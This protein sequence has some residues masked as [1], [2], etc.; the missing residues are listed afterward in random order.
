MSEIEPT[1]NEAPTEN[2]PL[3]DE[4]VLVARKKEEEDDGD[5]SESEAILEDMKQLDVEKKENE[6][7]ENCS[8]KVQIKSSPTVIEDFIR[9]FLISNE[10]HESLD[11]FQREW[12][13]KLQR[14]D[15]ITAI[16]KIPDIYHQKEKL[17]SKVKYLQQN[18]DRMESITA[19]VKKTW[20][21]LR[22]E[23]DF[24]RMHHRRVLQEKNEL[25]KQLKRLK[26]YCDSYEPTIHSLRVKYENAK[27]EKMLFR[28]DRDKMS[29]KLDAMEEQIKNI[30]SN[31]T[32]NNK[33]STSSKRSC[34]QQ[35]NMKSSSFPTFSL[36]NPYLDSS[37]DE[38]VECVNVEKFSLSKTF[39]V[40]KHAVSKIA[41]HPTKD[42]VATAS[43]DMSWKLWTIPS[44]ELI[45]SGEGHKDWISSLS[46]DPSG[47]HLASASGDCSIKIW[48]FAKSCC[49]AT[50]EDHTSVVWNVKYHFESSNFIVS[51]S[52]D[53]TAKLWDIEKSKCKQTYRG[54]VDSVNCVEFQPYSNNIV[55]GSGDKTISFWDIR[56]ALC[57]QTFYGHHNSVNHVSFNKK[58]D[59]IMSCDA[60]GVVKIWD[61]RMIKEKKQINTGKYVHPCSHVIFDESGQRAVVA[62]DD[63]L[64]KI[65]DTTN[66]NHI[67][68]LAG[69]QDNV[70]CVLFSHNN[71]MLISCSS[72]CTMRLWQ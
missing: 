59:E 14:D 48:D 45:M 5:V 33:S 36:R 10:M 29:V 6:D 49:V 55:T 63:A 9:N 37:N 41:L 2:K 17:E 57:I 11:V 58:C 27:K 46:F 61:I 50:F 20:D 3:N 28:I 34:T 35:I 69:H 21:N 51:C 42:I 38:N 19:K 39:S 30:E 66:G 54:H 64:I 25:M 44:G 68:S 23:R 52:M 67:E 71:K 16:S 62:S 53:H 1:V 70:N 18:L 43:D 47:A 15:E 8:K 4:T 32:Q 12:Y 40:H 56:S 13:N 24:H 72:D 60:D 7:K 65:Y 22:K 31:Y 26:K